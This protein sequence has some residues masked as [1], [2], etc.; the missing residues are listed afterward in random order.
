M[1]AQPL[2]DERGGFDEP[3]CALSGLN[4]RDSTKTCANLSFVGSDTQAENDPETCPNV[5]SFARSHKFS[6]MKLINMFWISCTAVCHSRAGPLP[7]TQRTA[8]WSPY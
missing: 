7:R 5:V 1:N 4:I 8:A 3:K 6:E 2:R